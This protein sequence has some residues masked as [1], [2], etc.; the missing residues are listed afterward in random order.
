MHQS[1]PHATATESM[2]PSTTNSLDQGF[3]F[4]ELLVT[5]TLIGIFAAIVA[6]GVGGFRAEAAESVCAS[7]QRHLWTAAEAYFQQ[8]ETT[9]I[10]A[11]GADNDRYERTLADD[12]FLRMVSDR[13]DLEA[14]GATTPQ[15]GS[16]C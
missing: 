7:D 14:S 3:S 16:P 15:G 1:E 6:I 8:N 5:I 12:G 2:V 13:H 4:V 11:T 9:T 10:P